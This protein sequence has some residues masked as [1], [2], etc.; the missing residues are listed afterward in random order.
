MRNCFWSLYN[1][2]DRIRI[3]GLSTVQLGGLLKTFAR[4]T[5]DE[6][7]V[8][9]EGASDWRE[10][11]E[12]SQ[13]FEKAELK[14]ALHP[15]TSVT[16]TATPLAT[17]AAATESQIT[18]TSKSEILKTTSATSTGTDGKSEADRQSAISLEVS[19]NMR[20][21]QRSSTRYP[22][23]FKVTLRVGAQV[24]TTN[25]RFDGRLA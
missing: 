10:A 20:T 21:E 22:H 4:Q 1:I 19:I 18:N 11:G 6:W 12:V 9:E 14:L 17:A 16:G 13:D 5:L 8:W 25:S 2:V 7:L 24:Q 3:D 23:H 15:P